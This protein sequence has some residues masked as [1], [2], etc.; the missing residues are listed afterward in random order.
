MYNYKEEKPVFTHSCDAPGCREA[1]EH[2]APKSRD[3]RPEYYWFCMDH[4]REYNKQ[5][6]Y[7]EG[8]NEE[9]IIAFQ[10]DARRG[11]RPTW[12]HQ[13]RPTLEDKLFQAASFFFFFQQQQKAPQEKATPLSRALDVMGLERNVT[14]TDVKSRYKILVKRYHPDHHQGDREAEERFKCVTEAYHVLMEHYR[15]ARAS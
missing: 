14:L 3:E 13:V 15:E 1:G 10:D 9:E 8:M 11:H 7:F 6:N 2:R 5:W 12:N 4:V